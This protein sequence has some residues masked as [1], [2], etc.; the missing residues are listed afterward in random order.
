MVLDSHLV[1][2]VEAVRLA[3]VEKVRVLRCFGLVRKKDFAFVRR[4][5]P[6]TGLTLCMLRGKAPK[7]RTQRTWSP[8]LENIFC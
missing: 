6:A 4:D 7:A 8:V 5:F 3:L 1:E 2:K